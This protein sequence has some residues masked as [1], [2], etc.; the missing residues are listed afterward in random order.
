M[1]KSDFAYALFDQLLGCSH[2]RQTDSLLSTIF[3][4]VNAPGPSV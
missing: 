3:I 4:Q 1:R 2:L